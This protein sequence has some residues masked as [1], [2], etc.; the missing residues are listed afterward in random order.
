[1]RHVKTVY[2][3]EN[4]KQSPVSKDAIEAKEKKAA[5]FGG[6]KKEGQSEYRVGKVKGNKK[7]TKGW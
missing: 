4:Q 5:A 2:N 1:M 3:F 6:D 7:N